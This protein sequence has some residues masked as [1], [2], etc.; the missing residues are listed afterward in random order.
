MATTKGFWRNVLTGD[1][2]VIESTTFGKV[3]GGT[4]PLDTLALHDL[5][6]YNCTPAI[7]E[8]LVRAVTENKLQRINLAQCR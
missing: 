4:G 6:D 5:D 1:V 3:V 8:W 7:L 2:Y